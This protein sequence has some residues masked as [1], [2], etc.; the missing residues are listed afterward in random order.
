[1][2]TKITNKTL[3][4]SFNLLLFLQ[5][6]RAEDVVLFENGV[7]VEEYEERVGMIWEG[8]TV[9]FSDNHKFTLLNKL[10]NGST[11]EIY[12]IG[13]GRALRIS[14]TAPDDLNLTQLFYKGHQQLQ[15]AKVPVVQV[16]YKPSI[17]EFVVVE[18]VD[19]LFDLK[20]FF[21]TLEHNSFEFTHILDKLYNF[22]ES[23]WSFFEIDDFSPS[24]LI[25]D[26]HKWVLIDILDDNKVFDLSEMADREHAMRV[27]TFSSSIFNF[28]P[29]HIRMKIGQLVYAKRAAFLSAKTCF[30][31]IQKFVYSI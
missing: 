13:G 17:G 15:Q 10:G 6:V 2:S 9:V 5:I 14:K 21:K 23:T 26:G 12:S 8:D 4:I 25:W 28:M 7:P 24:Q 27:N 29:S 11:T 18:E 1:M 16:V 30:E 20:S 19:K 22:V 3:I 31:S